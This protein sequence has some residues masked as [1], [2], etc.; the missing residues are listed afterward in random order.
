MPANDPPQQPYSPDQDPNRTVSYRPQY[1]RQ[2]QY[3]Q[4]QGQPQGQQYGQQ[5]YGQQY[6]QPQYGQPQYGQPQYGQQQYGQPG[7]QQQAA[8]EPQTLRAPQPPWAQ[9]GEVIGTG[10]GGQEPPRKKRGW[11][12]AVV[13]AIIV[14]LL[15]GGGYAAVNLLSGGGAQPQ[16]VLPGN[17]LAY[18]RLDLDPAAN[19]KVALFN[20]ARKFTVTKDSFTGD[21]PRKA[22]IEMLKQ[23]SPQLKDIDYAK[24]IEP[25]LGQRVGIAI[26][27]PKQSGGEPQVVAAVQVTDQEAA[28]A[29][30]AKLNGK[31]SDTAVAFR[32]DYALIGDDKGLIDQTAAGGETLGQNADFSGDMSALGEPGVLS[33]WM[34]LDAVAKASGALTAQQQ[35]SLKQIEGARFAGALRF[36]SSYAELAGVVRGAKNIVTGEPAGAQL[37]GLPAS[38]VGALSI[39]GLGEALTK[40]W[41]EIMKMADAS[42]S[43]GGQTFQQQV[44]ALQQ[45]TGLRLPQDLAT[46]LGKNVTL[47]LDEQGLDQQIPNIGARLA[48]DPAAAEQVVA[49]LE[50]ALNQAATATGTTTGT[51]TGTT[52]GAPQIFK[53]KG[54]GTY[55]IASSQ[56]YADQLAKGGTLGDSEAFQTA[57]PNADEAT[58]ALF[59]D[60]DKLEKL[61]LQNLQGDERA[62]VQVLRAVGMSGSSTADQA[63]FSLRVLFN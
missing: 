37:T 16:D 42:A 25:W 27:A 21:D 53:A 20:L 13:T 26:L 4:P 61:Y 59:V 11:I 56:Q 1:G 32:D 10:P 30:I 34:D 6:G 23:S 22:V 41:A 54:D 48:T 57:V 9:G 33:F 29:G 31:D 18:I 44:D 12:L 38:T 62:N 63:N 36:D 45:G 2:P 17:A 35:Q 24:D 7:Y 19:Q 55:I 60:L 39:S 43:P 51:A 5:P 3:G 15:G 46:L 49:K 52:T 14:A 58:F 28:R 47:A 40:Q 8:H 50:R